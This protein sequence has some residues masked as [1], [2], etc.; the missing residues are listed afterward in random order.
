ML[1]GCAFWGASKEIGTEIPIDAPAFPMTAPWTDGA[2]IPATYTCD[3]EEVSP[4]LH[5]PSFPAKT[6]HLA[7]LMEDPDA[8]AGTWVHWL[9][10]DSPAGDVKRDS[11]PGISGKNSWGRI[12]YGG[13]CPPSGGHRYFL[14]AYALSGPLGLPAGS[15]KAAF[16]AAVQEKAVG[17]ASV[18]GTYER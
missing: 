6:T 2:P 5:F 9:W 12:G 13:P 11:E 10:W 15:D 7:V 4:E 18:M 17:Y 16:A 3:G 8:P 14:H 1:T